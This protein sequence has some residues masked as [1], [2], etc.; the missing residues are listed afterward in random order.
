MAK[1]RYSNDH[2]IQIV[3]DTQTLNIGRN[4]NVLDDVTVG[5][6]VAVTG[7]I[8][9]PTINITGGDLTLT[10][11]LTVEESIIA[12][13]VEIGDTLRRE[14]AET[15]C[16]NLPAS[17]FVPM[18][19]WASGFTHQVDSAGDG[20]LVSAGNSLQGSH[21]LAMLPNGCTIQ[22]LRIRYQPEAASG[23]S[24]TAT[25]ISR[26]K[27]LGN[28]STVATVTETSGTDGFWNI[29][30]TTSIDETIDTTNFTYWVVF[31]VDAPPGD[32]IELKEINVDCDVT[33]YS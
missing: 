8:T 15:I 6:D 29:A 23:Y 10:G 11:D 24:V 17:A 2:T 28:V 1:D 33:D 27:F 31:D 3:G 5:G 7:T 16:F 20:V 19:N 25:L 18:G 13:N 30:S 26:G 21:N 4:L 12:E 22:A 9:T 32:D 14:F